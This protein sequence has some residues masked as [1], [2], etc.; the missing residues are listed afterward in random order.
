[1]TLPV[2]PQ[3]WQAAPSSWP[4]PPQVGQMFSPAPGVPGG[5]SSPGPISLVGS[6]LTCSPPC[7]AS[8]S[9]GTLEDGGDALAAAD[10]HGDQRPPAPGALELVQRLDGQDGAGGPDRVPERHP[11]AVGVG[12]VLGQ[13]Q[14]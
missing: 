9:R 8:V 12:A 11:G 6:P 13:A 3:V 10:A 14:V 5:A 7:P 4:V 1:M 2:P